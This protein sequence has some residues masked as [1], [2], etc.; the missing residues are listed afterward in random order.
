MVLFQNEPCS[1]DEMWLYHK[2]TPF[3]TASSFADFKIV[4]CS[5][6]YSFSELVQRIF[7]LEKWHLAVNCHLD[8]SSCR[9]FVALTTSPV[10]HNAPTC[11]KC[12]QNRTVRGWVIA[13]A[14]ETQTL[15]FIYLNFVSS[16]ND[17]KQN[18]RN[19]GIADD[20][21]NRRELVHLHGTYT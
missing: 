12:Q 6:S 10:C 19:N 7:K 16:D 15:F 11:T 14:L 21:G 1:G 20:T 2:V 5:V 9:S 17:I 13:S 3:A 18:N 8:R 4:A